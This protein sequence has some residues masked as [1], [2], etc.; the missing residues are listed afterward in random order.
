MKCLYF[1]R[2]LPTYYCLCPP[3]IALPPEFG[4]WRKQEEAGKYCKL[5]KC[6]AASK[7]SC[8]QTRTQYFCHRS[9]EAR[10]SESKGLRLMKSQG[11]CKKG[12][13]CL[14]FMT[15]TRGNSAGRPTSVALKVAYQM[16]HYG[17]A[18]NV[19][20]LSMTEKQCADVAV[21][22]RGVPMS[23]VLKNIIESDRATW[24]QCI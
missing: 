7:L 9:G 20:N 13:T 15:V 14:P 23:T 11:S 24:S 17:H 12:T 10:P 16:N 18:P 1:K 8:G 4:A 2:L 21:P 19:A 3:N 6:K 5:I 22:F